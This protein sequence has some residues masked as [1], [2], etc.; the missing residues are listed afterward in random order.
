MM[1]LDERD[2]TRRHHAERP[3]A[4]GELGR[5][6]PLLFG[7]RELL[8]G[9]GQ[10]GRLLLQLLQP[11]GVLG[12]HRVQQQQYDEAGRQDRADEDRERKAG[13]GERLAGNQT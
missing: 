8:L 6:L 13:C 4:R 2:R 7:Q 5:R 9:V 12:G 11:E 10:R 3:C 1:Q